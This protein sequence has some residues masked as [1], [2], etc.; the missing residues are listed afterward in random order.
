ML[1]LAEVQV[2]KAGLLGGGKAELKLLAC[3]RAEQSW[4][5]VSG[6]EVIA[7]DD[8]SNYSP[9]ALV[10]VD[11]GGNR[12]VQRIQDAGRQLVGILQNFSKLQERFKGQE[13][14]IEQWKQSLTYQSQE[15]NRR[16]MEM[17]SRQAQLEEMEQD[18][19]QFEQQ[20][21]EIAASREEVEQLQ[22][23]IERKNQELEGAWA[24]LR[25]EMQKLEERQDDMQAAQGLDA[26]EAQRIQASLEQLSGLLNAADVLPTE[27]EALFGLVGQQQEILNQHWQNLEQQQ[28]AVGQLQTEVEQ[29]S[30]SLQEGWQALQQSVDALVDAKANLVTQQTTLSLKEAQLAVITERCKSGTSIADRLQELAQMAGQSRS[31]SKVDTQAL[32]DLPIDKL[33]AVVQDLEKDLEKVVRFVND[34]EEELAFELQAI[35][36]LQQK[37]AAASDYDRLSLENELTEERDRYQMLNETLV[38]QRRNLQEREEVLIQHQ[39]ILNRRQGLPAPEGADVASLIDISPVLSELDVLRQQQDTE[40]QQLE[41]EL[42][43]LRQS[44]ATAQTAV[45]QQL[46]EQGQQRQSLE[47]QQREL[48]AQQVNVSELQGKIHLYEETLQPIQNALDG[49]RQKLEESQSAIAQLQEN[50]AAQS[51][52]VTDI[53][54]AIQSASAQQSPELAAS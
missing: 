34:Q 36:E 8:A 25:G 9:G 15:L 37:I 11:I 33:Q 41:A 20:R 40:R 52:I 7:A 23:D 45:D 1:Y 49:L 43:N 32:E 48:Q 17:E 2:K 12:Q 46:T 6:D 50:R 47:E 53:Q 26:A 42:D 16:E 18:I 30:Q 13:D 29:R 31:S 19:E 22:A 14:E 35:E 44:V 3:Q 5:A 38:G 4:S 27:I 39:A 10:M 24:H 21:Q 51:Q 28:A 54:Q